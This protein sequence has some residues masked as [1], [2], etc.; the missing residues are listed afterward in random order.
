MGL[1]SRANFAISLT[2][3]NFSFSSTDGS[4][5]FNAF[6]IDFSSDKRTGMTPHAHELA[7]GVQADASLQ[8]D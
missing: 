2:E 8:E 1:V 7:R 3:S 5:H 4:P 6:A